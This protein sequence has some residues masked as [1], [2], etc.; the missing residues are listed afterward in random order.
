MVPS[1]TEPVSGRE[2]VYDIITYYRDAIQFITDQTVRLL[3]LGYEADEIVKRVRLPSRVASHP[4]LQEHY[5]M[6]CWSV[7]SVITGTIGWYD[8]DPIN[9]FPISKQSKI[10]RL[11]QLLCREFEKNTSGIEKMLLVAQ[12]AM[13]NGKKPSQTDMVWSLDLSLKA[14]KLSIPESQLHKKAQD[15]ATSCLNAM[16]ASM[17]NPVARNS[18]LMFIKCLS[19]KDLLQKGSEARQLVRI[20]AWPMNFVMEKLRYSLRA[21]DC[22]DTDTM[23]VV[24]MFPDLSQ[25]HSYTL[26]HSIL[27]YHNKPGLIPKEFDLKLTTN[28]EVLRDLLTKERTVSSLTENGELQMEGNVQTLRK[29]MDL[30]DVCKASLN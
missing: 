23:T 14:L 9:L 8:R 20:K 25:E 15:V 3:N 4:Y 13:E 17:V 16:A 19:T 29:F 22:S 2:K 1:H 5:G 21:E 12:E 24:F 10:E 18:F 6:V 28:S 26:R 27:E 30:V 7:R 11:N